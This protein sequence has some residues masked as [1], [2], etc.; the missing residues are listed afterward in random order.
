MADSQTDFKRANPNDGWSYGYYYRTSA[1][2]SLYLNTQ[3]SASISGYMYATSYARITS[4]TLHPNAAA[5]CTT[6]SFG[7]IKPSIAWQNPEMVERG[8]YRI[9][10]SAS[11]AHGCGD[12]I[13]LTLLIDGQQAAY[14]TNPIGT[15]T[16]NDIFIRESIQSLELIQDP[17]SGCNCDQTTFRIQIYGAQVS[18][19][20]SP[21]P[22]ES[23]SQT[24][25]SSLSP[26]SSPSASITSTV[27]SSETITPSNSQSSSL[28][29]SSTPSI[30]I[31]STVTS[32]E[33][34]SSSITPTSTS[35]ASIT[36]SET[37][38]VTM[39]PTITLNY[40]PPKSPSNSRSITPTK[41]ITL[42]ATPTISQSESVGFWDQE[43]SLTPTTS[44][45][46]SVSSSISGSNS[47]ST[48]SS[49]SKSGSYSGTP[50]TSS[51]ATHSESPSA[52]ATTS[53]SISATASPSISA[54]ASPSNSAT[55]SPSTSATTSPSTSATTSPSISATASPSTSATASP[56]NSLTTSPS[57]SA[58]ASPS[59]SLTNSPSNSLT[60]S[61]SIS[62]TASPSNS[63]TNSPS[64]SLTTSPSNSLTNSPSNSLTTSPGNSATTSPST[65]AT[66]SPSTSATTSPS[67]SQTPTQ[68]SEASAFQNI[69]GPISPE[70]FD[71]LLTSFGSDL[72]SVS[73]TQAFY[74]LTNLVAALGTEN[75]DPTRG[76]AII[77]ILANLQPSAETLASN[78]ALLQNLA[79]G[80]TNS[81]PVGQSLVLGDLASGFALAVIKVDP[82]A[83]GNLALGENS[84]LTIP[85]LGGVAAPLHFAA[86]GID[87]PTYSIGLSLNGT[88]IT[89]A[90]LSQPFVMG[91]PP[92]LNGPNASQVIQCEYYDPK[93]RAWQSDGCETNYDNITKQTQCSCTHLTEFAAR[94]K[95]LAD[96]QAG[97]GQ[98]FVDLFTKT[99]SGKVIP[100]LVFLIVMAGT[101]FL[102]IIFLNN[103]DKKAIGAYSK[104]LE[105]LPQLQEIRKAIN[106]K[107]DYVWDRFLTKAFFS[108]PRGA[109][110]RKVLRERAMPRGSTIKKILEFW[111]R[112][113][114]HQHFYTSLLVRYDPAT[115]R[116]LRAL[117]AMT[118]FF[119]SV[120]IV[121]FFYGYT[122]GSVNS[123]QLPEIT[124]AETFVLSLMTSALTTPIITILRIFM[125][126]AGEWE[127][128]VR[129]PELMAE[130]SRRRMFERALA[131]LPNEDIIKQGRPLLEK[132][133]A[134]PVAGDISSGSGS[135]SDSGS[136]SEKP[137]SKPKS[138]R[139]LSKPRLSNVVMTGT[140]TD[141]SQEVAAAAASVFTTLDQGSGNGNSATEALEVNFIF[142]AIRWLASHCSCGRRKAE[143]ESPSLQKIISHVVRQVPS[144]AATKEPCLPYRFFP[145]HTGKSW[146]L[147]GSMLGWTAFTMIYILAFTSYESSDVAA[148]VIRTVAISQAISNGVVAPI[149][150][151]SSIVI[152][153]V[154]TT[155]KNALKKPITKQ[156]F[157][158]PLVAPL[159]SALSVRLPAL[160]SKHP[161]CS[162]DKK[163]DVTLLPV[164]EIVDW[165][166][167]TPPAEINTTAMAIVRNLYISIFYI[168]LKKTTIIHPEEIKIDAG[169][170]TEERAYKD[171]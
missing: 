79:Q 27:T 69:T 150:Q 25:S 97:V 80:L 119:T 105:L 10:Y 15:I 46:V 1:V 26:S 68:S 31:T 91:F 135:D 36:P 90:N 117:F 19:S 164:S 141:A 40:T 78:S 104:M 137:K 110:V 128:N 35:S 171:L 99:L 96:V 6:P 129:Y 95:A 32:S 61:P 58:T 92:I 111:W 18:A 85:P 76:A 155:I 75:L 84:T 120:A 167:N 53:P 109:N 77:D 57:I 73:E 101:T 44:P 9:E 126:K 42:S 156:T 14:N 7:L 83:E 62:A 71:N 82:N 107:G 158:S 151:L 148:D 127:Y 70:R 11:Q 64:N 16:R 147:V 160:A 116:V 60:T 3:W 2:R 143:Q 142:Q 157:G 12:G 161:C 56:S 152:P 103:L 149:T 28:S 34:E 24:V 41:S 114:F 20:P 66:T 165:L 159:D 125:T 67:I 49:S 102:L 23:A 98:G 162:G 55:T 130:V 144:K 50:S 168:K 138:I 47:P 124:I 136:G 54:T 22:S 89:V 113:L 94:F 100:I 29:P 88:E 140:A 118:G 33:T 63:L 51:S 72:A 65:S 52:S 134:L 37:I 166:S 43:P 87:Q 86:S 145:V 48:T 170:F 30:S 146:I 45:S 121:I 133:E 132:I 4:S 115:P 122:N 39:T 5:E 17:R 154:L 163:V 106:L 8:Y 74:M 153:Y 139:S 131:Q 81:L 108:L 169:S 123:Q 112:R 21:S 38:T 59:N 93:T 13:A